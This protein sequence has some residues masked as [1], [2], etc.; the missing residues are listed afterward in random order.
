MR[1]TLLIESAGDGVLV[2]NGQFCGPMEREGQAFPCGENEEVYIQLFPFG[3]SMPLAA[4]LLLRGGKIATLVPQENCYALLWPDG[5]I[6]LE[7]RMQAMEREQADIVTG[8]RFV[9]E[10]KPFTMR[11]LGSRLIQWAIQLTTGQK[12]T[13]PT[14]GMRLL[15]RSMIGEFANNMNYGPEPDTIAYL[16]KTGVKLTEVQVEMHERQAGESYLKPL[17]SM[18]YMMRMLISILLLQSFRKREGAK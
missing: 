1:K 3:E 15:N 9:E 8:S 10:K 14:S 17:A 5:I 12:L 11:M 4:K 16:L 2:V 13:D 6:Q 7:L 18:R